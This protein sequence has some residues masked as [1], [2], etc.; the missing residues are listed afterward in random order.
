MTVLLAVS[1]NSPWAA[2]RE[3]SSLQGPNLQTANRMEANLHAES[4]VTH[5]YGHG[6]GGRREVPAT[7][8]LPTRDATS[9]CMLHA[10]DA[11]ELVPS[12]YIELERH[13]FYCIFGRYV[14]V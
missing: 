1:K 6:L 13:P 5:G 8:R 12:I 4:G 3:Y 2:L 9:F 14:A 11:H 7:L 10:V